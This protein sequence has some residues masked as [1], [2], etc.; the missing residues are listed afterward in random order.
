[1]PA[2][3]PGVAIPIMMPFGMPGMAV[4]ITM[5]SMSIIAPMFSV[6]MRPVIGMVFVVMPLIIVSLIVVASVGPGI[7]RIAII[8]VIGLTIGV[9]AVRAIPVIISISMASARISKPENAVADIEAYAGGGG[10][11]GTGAKNKE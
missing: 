6:M 5:P 3:M 2:G 7:I 1:M 4:L 11:G 8:V 10:C 9:P